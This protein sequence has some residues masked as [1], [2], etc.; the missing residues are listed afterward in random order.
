MGQP[1]TSQKGRA[2]GPEHDAPATKP[3]LPIDSNADPESQYQT[4]GRQGIKKE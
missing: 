3:E 4:W 1:A 2:R